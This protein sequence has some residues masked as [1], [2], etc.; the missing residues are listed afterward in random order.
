MESIVVCLKLPRP[1]QLVLHPHF[2]DVADS[3][4]LQ[5][6]VSEVDGLPRRRNQSEIAA[7]NQ[8]KSYHVPGEFEQQSNGRIEPPGI[9]GL[10]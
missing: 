2:S 9:E 3:V 8:N 1:L 10:V 5:A 6:P 4:S 7:L